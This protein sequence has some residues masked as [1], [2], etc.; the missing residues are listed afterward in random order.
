[1][2]AVLKDR[3]TRFER[4]YVYVILAKCLPILFYGLDYVNISSKFVQAETKVWNMAFRWVLGL[5]K[6]DLTRLVLKSCH[7]MSAK[8]LLDKSVLLFYNNIVVST[9]AS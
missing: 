3:I 6:Y 2:S 1:M 4:V 9:L 7:T 5:K 8:F